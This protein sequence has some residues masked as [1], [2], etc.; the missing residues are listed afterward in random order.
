MAL[1]GGYDLD[2]LKTASE[3]CLRALL[4]LPIEKIAEEELARRPCPP[5][6]N[7]DCGVHSELSELR[8]VQY[9]YRPVSRNYHADGTS[10]LSH[11]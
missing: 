6:K 4:D 1:E 8:F 9:G 11:L 2:V 3:Q 5:G 7:S 10:W